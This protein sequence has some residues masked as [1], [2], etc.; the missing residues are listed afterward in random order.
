MRKEYAR[1]YVAVIPPPQQR[2][3]Q[4]IDALLNAELIA[5]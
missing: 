5:N 2:G 4:N 1:V 3:K